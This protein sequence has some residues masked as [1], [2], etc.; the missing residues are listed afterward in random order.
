MVYYLYRFYSPQLG[1][2]INRDPIEEAG[3]INLYGFVGND[4]VNKIDALGLMSVGNITNNPVTRI[5]PL[6][7]WDWYLLVKWLYKVPSGFPDQLLK[8]YIFGKGKSLTMEDD[9]FKKYKRSFNSSMLS[10]Q[11]FR[12]DLVAKCTKATS[13]EGSYKILKSE[14]TVNP[15]AGLN[16]HYYKFDVKVDCCPDTNNRYRWKV[17]GKGSIEDQWDFEIDLKTL[18]DDFERRNIITFAGSFIPGVKFEVL[19]NN[20]DMSQNFG[21][22]KGRNTYILWKD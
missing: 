4:V 9:E 12:I 15:K 21:F 11:E 22:D 17:K 5:N 20:S 14:D 13:W 10:S 8:N 18:I 19:S 2:W 16:K 6:V 1:R 3:G 7:Q